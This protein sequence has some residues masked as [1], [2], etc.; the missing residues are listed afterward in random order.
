MIKT[1]RP[2]IALWL[3]FAPDHL[4][5]YRSVAQ[6]RAAKLRVFENQT[7]DD[8]AIVNA[9]D[10]LPE[11]RARTEFLHL[12]AEKGVSRTDHTVTITEGRSVLTGV[13][14]VVDTKKHQFMLQSQVKGTFDAP[15]RK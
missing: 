11:L 9:L 15:N 2:A 13:G 10:N 1:F 7:A 3:N 12:L 4:D 6:Y 5:R 8:V 14:M